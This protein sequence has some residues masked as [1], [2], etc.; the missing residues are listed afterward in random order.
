[1]TPVGL[2]KLG[3]SGVQKYMFCLH[4]SVC[5]VDETGKYRRRGDL[6][7]NGCLRNATENR[8]EGGE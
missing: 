8:I 2:Y 4:A 1:L 5:L 6:K 7:C 3:N